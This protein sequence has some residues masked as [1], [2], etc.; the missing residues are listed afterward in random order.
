M[1]SMQ[2]GT[3]DL[4]KL[5]GVS[6]KFVGLAKEMTGVI[7]NNDR[8][9]KAG[10]AQQERATENLKA[11]R[12]EARAEGKEQKA[13]SIAKTQDDDSGSGVIAQAKGRVKEAAGGIIGDSD[14][15][16][17]G[18]ADQDRGASQRS[19]TKDRTEAKAHEAKAKVAEKSQ[20]AAERS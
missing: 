8:L 18:G 9:Q 5:R 1:E 4:D 20:E 2:I 10:E 14:L 11:L 13:R 3:V 7:A 12:S 15:Q 19:A 6:D 16:S 17:D